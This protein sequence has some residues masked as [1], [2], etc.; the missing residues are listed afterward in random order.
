M[1][2]GWPTTFPCF[3]HSSSLRLTLDSG[4]FQLLPPGKL[5]NPEKMR[6]KRDSF[7]KEWIAP[8]LWFWMHRD[9]CSGR[10]GIPKHSH[11][12]CAATS[13]ADAGAGC[14][15]C[16]LWRMYIAPTLPRSVCSAV[17]LLPFIWKR[18]IRYFGLGQIIHC[19]WHCTAMLWIIGDFQQRKLQQSTLGALLI[20]AAF[21]SPS[22]S[23][24]CNVAHWCTLCKKLI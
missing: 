11:M 6:S 4:L 3:G 19:R 2:S 7:L 14:P 1:K 12:W 24:W 16:I 5:G 18:V 17:S 8:Q 13:I 9:W 20:V 23:D 10:F 22:W 21:Q 15:R